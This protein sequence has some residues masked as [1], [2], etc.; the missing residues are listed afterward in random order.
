MKST[1]SIDHDVSVPR[2]DR[3]AAS[4]V[5]PWFV[6]GLALLLTLGAWWFVDEERSRDEARQFDGL[7]ATVAQR[8]DAHFL[9]TEQAVRAAASFVSA[10]EQVTSDD[11]E[12]FVRGLQLPETTFPGA[13]GIGYIQRVPANELSARVEGQR[14]IQAGYSVRPEGA[15]ADRFPMVYLCHFGGGCQAV[16]SDST[17]R[18]TRRVVKGSTGRWRRRGWRTRG[19]PR[20]DPALARTGSISWLPGP[21]S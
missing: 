20:I 13:L 4:A 5:A 11:R 14:R 21:R 10:S 7:V 9:A 1:P 6:L 18:P 15:P 16:R 3:R 17:P 8:V 19:L 12:R 2:T